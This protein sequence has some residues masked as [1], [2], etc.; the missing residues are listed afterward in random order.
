LTL[1]H[2]FAKSKDP[3]KTNQKT[4][5]VYSIRCEKEY[6]GQSKRHF[7]TQLKEHQ[8]GKSAL[9]EHVCYTKHEI[10]WENTKVIT[11]NNRYTARNA[12]DLLQVVNFTGLLQ[13]VNKLQ[14][15]C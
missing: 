2:I 10:V 1:G 4:H 5:A 6:L 15:A 7:G 9:A 8:K 11:T 12:T 3:V 13:L 14:Q